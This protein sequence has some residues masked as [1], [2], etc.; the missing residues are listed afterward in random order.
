[1]HMKEKKHIDELFKNRFKNFEATPSPQVWENIQAALKE[2]K[3]DRKIIPLWWK[4]GGVAALFALLL[5]VGNAV[6]NTGSESPVLTNDNTQKQTEKNQSNSPTLNNDTVTDTEFASEND[7]TTQD[8]KEELNTNS[9]DR[10][11]NNKETLYKKSK[12]KGNAVV[13]SE[14]EKTSEKIKTT[15]NNPLIKKDAST[16]IPNNNDGIGDATE[17]KNVSEKTTSEK[18]KKSDLIKENGGSETIKTE[19]A[20]PFKEPNNTEIKET[21]KIAKTDEVKIEVPQ[22]KK[23]IFDAIEEQKTEEAVAVKNTKPDTR[24][25]VAPNVGPVYYNT[26]SNGSSIDP[27]FADN[28]Q[29]GDV[30]ITYGINVS[31]AISNRLSVRSGVSN[32][33]LSYSTGG[34]E[35]GN[36]PISSA[37]RSIDYGGRQNVLTVLDKG[38]LAMQTEG[39]PFGNITPKST[40]GET[41]LN[42]SITYY[43]VPLELKYAVINKKLGVNVIGG[44]STLFLGNNEVSVSA[45]DF[46]SVLGEA[47]NLSS[48]SFSTNIGLGFNYKLSKKFLFNIEPMFKYQLNPYTDSSVDFKPYYI[49]VYSGLSFKF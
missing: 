33:D 20:T 32:V 38:T 19:V 30:N 21:T 12:E 28:S 16:I 3:K 35:L 14:K 47:N 24:W 2:E 40:N 31:Y 45:G 27:S 18:N 15:N 17:K 42:Q 1:M 29:T 6:F 13:N 5:T 41:R 26:L 9:K 36:G 43:E 10:S 25:E 39:G 49:G 44:L 11:L 23:S 37:L 34:L 7:N 22:N 46:N 4:L 8:I 48:V